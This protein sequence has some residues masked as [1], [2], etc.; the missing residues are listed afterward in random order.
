MLGIMGQLPDEDDPWAL[1]D[2]LLAALPPGSHLAL[3]DGTN[4]SDSLNQAVASYNANSASSYHLR[5]P[6]RIADFF[7]G[8]DLVEPGVVRTST[9]RPDPG[10]N[11]EDTLQ[12]HSV[13]GVALKA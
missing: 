10:Q 13:S 5:S 8:L 7:H 11:P 3:S 2:R 9:W 12:G 1:A 6:E 4:T